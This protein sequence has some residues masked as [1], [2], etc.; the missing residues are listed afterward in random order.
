MDNLLEE[1]RSK[2]NSMIS[3]NEYTYE[4]ILKVSQ[5]LDFQIVNYYN[6]NVKRKQMAI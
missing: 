1:L 4:E 2:L 5:E 3:S 6:S